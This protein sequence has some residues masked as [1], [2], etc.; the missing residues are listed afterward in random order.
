MSSST[1]I[2][3]NSSCARCHRTQDQLSEPMR[4][5]TGCRSVL[6]CSRECQKLAWK[7]HKPSCRTVQPGETPPVHN[8]RTTMSMKYM[9]FQKLAGGESS[10][11]TSGDGGS[12]GD[13]DTIY[14]LETSTPHTY[15]ISVSGPYCPHDAIIPQVLRNFGEECLHGQYRFPPTATTIPRANMSFTTASLRSFHGIHPRR[16]RRRLRTHHIAH[17]QQPQLNEDN[18]PHPRAQPN[19]SFQTPR[20]RVGHHANRDAPRYGRDAKPPRRFHPPSRPKPDSKRDVRDSERSKH[21]AAADCGGVGGDD[22]GLE[23]G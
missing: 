6:Y 10:T 9:D 17:Q 11:S 22:S 14:Y 23:G 7:T 12:S 3:P 19:P 4:R 21:P 18:P 5:C 15:D 13:T 8:N 2:P 1:T 20:S 16:P